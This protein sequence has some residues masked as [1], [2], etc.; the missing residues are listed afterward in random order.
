MAP[1]RKLI[2]TLSVAA[3]VAPLAA[4][5]STVVKPQLCDP[6]WAPQQRARAV[7]FDPY[8]Q[9]DVGPEIVGGRPPDFAVPPNEVTRAFQNNPLPRQSSAPLPVVMPPEPLH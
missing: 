1:L 7:Q 9:N 6:G 5:S 4:C 2:A 8:P 3:I